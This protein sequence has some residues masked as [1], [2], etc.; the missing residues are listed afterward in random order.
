[1]SSC[2]K[3][4]NPNSHKDVIGI[5]DPE[6]DPVLEPRQ[7]YF[8]LFSFYLLLLLPSAL[9]LPLSSIIF[10]LVKRKPTYSGQHLEVL[11][12]AEE[13][14]SHFS[15]TN[16][17]TWLASFISLKM[18]RS[19]SWQLFHL[20][21]YHGKISSI[22][23]GICYLRYSLKRG[24]VVYVEHFSILVNNR[25]LNIWSVIALYSSSSI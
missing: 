11:V 14:R 20:F 16:A 4:I 7:T 22:C 19:H 18:L 9:S 10:P 24:K 3:R 5:A 2:S 25:I 23:I 21:I 8:L 17:C 12:M 1:M 6:A 15:F 13:S